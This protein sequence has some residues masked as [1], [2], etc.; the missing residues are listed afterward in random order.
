MHARTILRCM[1]PV[2]V[3]GTACTAGAKSEPQTRTLYL[4]APGATRAGAELKL[5][6]GPEQMSEGDAF[7]LYDKVMKALSKDLD[8]AKIRNWRQVPLGELP[9][10]EVEPVLRSFDACLPWLEQAGRCRRCEWP[11]YGTDEA[12]VDLQ[13]Y[14]NFVFLVALKARSQLAR[15]ESESC[16]RTLGTGLA[17]AKHLGAGPTVIHLLVGSALSAL[18][19]SEVELYVQ[20]PGA[21]S[22]EAALRAVPR[23]LFDEEHSDLYGMDEAG[24]SKIRLVFAR[25]NRHLIALQYIETLRACA[26]KVEKWPQTLAELQADL[27]NDPVTGT[28]FAY[29]RIDER[30][31]LLEEPVPDGG[32]VKD[33]IRYELNLVKD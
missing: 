11:L 1:L 8:W 6:P 32:G 15:G 5:L 2:I 23:P 19:G 18:I 10:T 9:L 16:V 30:R 27:P 13:A 17:L 3:F 20:Q 22:L 33:G 24:R 4:H 31:A 25:A 12:P 7:V 21:P 26:A 29:R 28:S 14:R